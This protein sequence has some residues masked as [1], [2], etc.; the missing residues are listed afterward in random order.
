MST[1]TKSEINATLFMP[2]YSLLLGTI[3]TGTVDCLATT[4]VSLP[5]I[6]SVKAPPPFIPK[7]I[8]LAFT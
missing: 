8:I 2:E 3:I 5:I 7:I 1:S 6:F 4:T